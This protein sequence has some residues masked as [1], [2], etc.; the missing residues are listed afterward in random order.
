MKCAKK[1]LRGNVY[2]HS[3]GYIGPLQAC[4]SVFFTTLEGVK[5]NEAQTQND[6][7]VE[8]ALIGLVPGLGWGLRP[9]LSKKLF[10]VR[11]VT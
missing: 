8:S 7:V 11:R 1:V 9:P 4:T 10:P 3:I 2:V 5:P 6:R